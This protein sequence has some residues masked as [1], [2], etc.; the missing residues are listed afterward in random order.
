MA[1]NACVRTYAYNGDGLR[2]SHTPACYG[3]ALVEVYWCTDPATSGL[4]SLYA[5]PTAVEC[6]MESR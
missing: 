2:A 1:D 4:C 6:L 5:E 3:Y